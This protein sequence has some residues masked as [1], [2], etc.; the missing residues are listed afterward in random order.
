MGADDFTR[1]NI[2][3]NSMLVAF[4]R[5]RRS[6]SSRACTSGSISSATRSAANLNFSSKGVED[7]SSRQQGREAKNSLTMACAPPFSL[8][9]SSNRKG[10]AWYLTLAVLG[11][12]V[13]RGYGGRV[14]GW[15]GGQVC[16]ASWPAGR[17]GL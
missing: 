15:L 9:N 11:R 1:A 6:W 7:P 16:A 12:E 3:S 14:V 5:F 17:A 8:R 4:T 13:S 2:D 10:H